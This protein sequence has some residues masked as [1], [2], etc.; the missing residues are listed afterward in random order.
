MF[1]NSHDL[2]DDLKIPYV[3]EDLINYLKTIFNPNSL[4]DHEASTAEALI[5]YMQGCRDVI[6][7]LETLRE[8]RGDDV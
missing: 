6:T 2:E 5:G 4:L 1:T 8:S 7:H 3:S